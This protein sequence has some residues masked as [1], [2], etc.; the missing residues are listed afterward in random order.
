[1]KQ[2][3]LMLLAV[4]LLSSANAFAQSGNSEPLK[5]DVNGDGVVDVADIAAIID[6]MANGGG[7][8]STTTYYWYVGTTQ[9]TDPTD[10]AQNTGLNKWTSIGTNL[11]TSDIYINKVDTNYE[12]HT[13]YIAAPSDSNFTLY[14][15]T[16]VASDEAGWNK[17]TFNVGSVQ[18]TLW[19]SKA[20][21][22]QAV[23]YL[24]K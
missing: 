16:N 15:G 11:P 2:K 8:V 3:I 4:V 21:S 17:S 18:Y 10:S 9:P 1:M 20:T 7:P 13:W 24:H 14:N 22:Y 12:L 6:I 19:T 5:G 23:G